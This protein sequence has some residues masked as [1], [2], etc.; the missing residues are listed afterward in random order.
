MTVIDLRVMEGWGTGKGY[1]GQ[2]QDEIAN[3]ILGITVYV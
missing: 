1:Q 2:I 3:I